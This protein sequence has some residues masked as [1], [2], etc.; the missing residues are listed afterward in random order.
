[1][2]NNIILGT[3]II[4]PIS[5]ASGS[6][7][8]DVVI[9]TGSSGVVEGRLSGVAAYRRAAGQKVFQQLSTIALNTEEFSESQYD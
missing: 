8:V 5:I 7:D 6:S 4:Y 3:K 9:C 2:A 1:M